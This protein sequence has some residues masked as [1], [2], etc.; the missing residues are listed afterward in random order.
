MSTIKLTNEL[1]LPCGAVIKNRIGKS[2]MSE[3]L[4]TKEHLSTDALNT[5]YA[6]WAN[7]G[8]GLESGKMS[9]NSWRI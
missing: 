2:A 4:G 7:G 1:K 9:G 8:S 6:R 3:N 5:L